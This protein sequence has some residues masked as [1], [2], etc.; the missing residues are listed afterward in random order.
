MTTDADP[1][2]ATYLCPGQ[3][4]AIFPQNSD[5]DVEKCLSAFGWKKDELL[6]NDTVGELLKT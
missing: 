2:N 4:V 1:K 3:S 6:G 5:E